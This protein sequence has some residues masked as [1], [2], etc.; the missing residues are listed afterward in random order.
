MS[1]VGSSNSSWAPRIGLLLGNPIPTVH[2]SHNKYNADIR[3]SESLS[4]NPSILGLSKPFNPDTMGTSIQNSDSEDEQPPVMCKPKKQHIQRNA[5][6]LQS[7]QKERRIA[8]NARERR[9]MNSINSAFDRLR[10]VLPQ[11]DGG[12]KMSKYEALQMAQQYIKCLDTILNGPSS[13]DYDTCD[14]QGQKRHAV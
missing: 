12:R 9:R 11:L 13:A 4:M 10:S 14:Q 8:A 6:S 1:I 5:P 7:I 2:L 3:T